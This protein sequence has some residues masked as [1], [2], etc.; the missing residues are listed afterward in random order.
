MAQNNRET[1]ASLT[2]KPEGPVT[3]EIRCAGNITSVSVVVTSSDGTV[4][5]NMLRSVSNLLQQAASGIDSKIVL[6]KDKPYGS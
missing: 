3:I 6:L 4:A 2:L 1:C 5:A